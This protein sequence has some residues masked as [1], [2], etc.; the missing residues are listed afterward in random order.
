MLEVPHGFN[1]FLGA[2]LSSLIL[3]LDL[4]G[5]Q[6]LLEAGI[7]AEVFVGYRV[8]LRKDVCHAE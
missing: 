1:E 5:H 7:R 6:V 8:R 2:A 3:A 4:T